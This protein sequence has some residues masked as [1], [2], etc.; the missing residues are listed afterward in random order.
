MLVFAAIVPHSPLL[1]PSI[2][3]THRKKMRCTLKALEEIEQALYVV[4][5][6]TVCIIAPHGIRY[7]DAYSINLSEKYLG[8]FKNFGDF[9]TNIEAKPDFLVIDHLQR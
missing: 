6:D 8:E 3:K 7:T 2:G 5:P 9:S 4:K 1:V